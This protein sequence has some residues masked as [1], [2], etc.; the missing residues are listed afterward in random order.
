[1]L[2]LL[3]S[4][5]NKETNDDALIR[6]E[7]FEKFLML[8]TKLTIVISPRPTPPE[9]KQKVENTYGRQCFDLFL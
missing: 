9:L 1:M 2:I 4:Q 5:F 7:I 8:N 6:R 3:T